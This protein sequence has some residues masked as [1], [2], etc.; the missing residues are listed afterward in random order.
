M[1]ADNIAGLLLVAI[2]LMT[3]AVVG[4][5]IDTSHAV[6]PTTPGAETVELGGL[7][8]DYLPSHYL[9]EQLAAPIEALPPQF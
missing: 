3:A 8:I 7:E 5:A 4:A 1:K 2:A 6:Q 9:Q